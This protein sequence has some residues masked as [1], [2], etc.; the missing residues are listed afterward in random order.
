M[1]RHVDLGAPEDLEEVEGF[2]CDPK[3]IVKA[4]P[5]WPPELKRAIRAYNSSDNELMDL[6][7]LIEEVAVAVGVHT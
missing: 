6:S 2:N 1:T 3:G 4:D 5:S 7:D